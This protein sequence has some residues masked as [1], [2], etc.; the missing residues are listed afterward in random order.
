MDHFLRRLRVIL[1]EE[2]SL[3]PGPMVVGVSGGLDSMVL[4]EALAK[5]APDLGLQ[6]TAAHLNHGLRGRA[7]DLD[8]Q[9]V[10]RTCL[11]LG[12]PHHGARIRIA[13]NDAATGESIEMKARRLRHRFLCE[14][15]S[16]AGS[17][18]V[19][20]AHHADDQA[21]LILLRI[22][23]GA[24]ADGLGGMR[25]VSPSPA[26]PR[27]R[28]V[29]PF[30]GF[31]RSELKEFAE[32][33]S[34]RFREDASNRDLSIPRNRI[35]HRILPFLMR[36]ISPAL[37]RVLGRMAIIAAGESE[38]L[39][40]QAERWRRSGR[41]GRFDRLPLALQRIVLRQEL[42]EVGQDVGFEVLEE[43][44]RKRASI[45]S[46]GKVSAKAKAGRPLRAC[47]EGP[48]PLAVDRKGI[49]E[50]PGGRLE[51]RLVRRRQ[52]PTAGVEQFDADRLGDL[53]VLRHRR[54][55][56]LYQ[57]MGMDRPGRLKR[58]FINRKVP[59]VE[60]GK[61]LVLE[62]ADGRIA[63]VE[64]FPPAE[65]FK[66]TDSTRRILLIRLALGD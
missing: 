3:K 56:D 52:K 33:E 32:T 26:D 54:S 34:I 47:L 5:L 66:L 18:R 8:A 31:K 64:G 60:R 25:P 50:V 39:N 29:R 20:L 35:R 27:V 49:Q 55:G 4:L 42:W 12:V 57:P 14:V 62:A 23:R 6:L 46:T 17:D 1:G 40:R 38:H 43:M 10:E 51:W 63:W 30:L 21:E 37:P 22:F 15:A 41:R 61:R 11:R 28:L 44:R 2:L 13:D 45:E 36:E 48:L 53:A 7:S 59:M 24:G 65:P 58:H 16:N 19:A 9:L